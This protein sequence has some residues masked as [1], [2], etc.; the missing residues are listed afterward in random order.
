MSLRS[1]QQIYVYGGEQHKSADHLQVP[2]ADQYSLVVHFNYKA[3][4]KL[5]LNTRGGVSERYTAAYSRHPATP[6]WSVTMLW[7]VL[8]AVSAAAVV[9]LQ[10][11]AA[12][13]SGQRDGH[14][15]GAATAGYRGRDQQDPPHKDPHRSQ[16]E[17][18]TPRH[19]WKHGD[20]QLHGGREHQE[21]FHETT[22][23]AMEPVT[24]ETSISTMAAAEPTTD[25]NTVAAAAPKPGVASL[26]T[27]LA[28][29]S[30][31]AAC[32]ADSSPLD[33]SADD[34]SSTLSKYTRYSIV[35]A[36]QN[37]NH[38]QVCLLGDVAHR[39]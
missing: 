30:S 19:L 27:Q 22:A 39:L 5:V 29:Y 10:P 4:E 13:A 31:P 32:S 14:H 3:A 15:R 25:M 18:A 34:V 23:A 9:S 17:A 12:A 8:L 7:S 2:P 16:E 38:H 36:S 28:A 37:H 21:R 24:A 11:A 20:G 35:L 6:L 26:L 33:V 1:S